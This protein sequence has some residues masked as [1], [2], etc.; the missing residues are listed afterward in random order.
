[1]GSSRWS[2]P[3]RQKE[4]RELL[5]ESIVQ[6]G[7][8]RSPILPQPGVA[9]PW[10]LVRMLDPCLPS[11]ARLRPTAIFAGGPIAFVCG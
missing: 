4:G 2:I 5:E 7:G 9:L 3:R 10:T 1:L 11:T 8:S 6:R